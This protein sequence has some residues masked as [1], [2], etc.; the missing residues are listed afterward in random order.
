MNVDEAKK[1]GIWH[2]CYPNCGINGDNQLI[3]IDRIEPGERITVDYST[4]F[5][6]N[7]FIFKCNCSSNGCRKL[8]AGF[9]QIPVIF[10]E[11][12]L[13]LGVVAREILKE[14]KNQT[15]RSIHRERKTS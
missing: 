1:A 11:K 2:S 6:G 7:S 4:L 14:F 12:Y 5:N 10:Q 15:F 8:I 9:D 3:V 13:K